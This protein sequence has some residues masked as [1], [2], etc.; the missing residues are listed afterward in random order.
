M[1]TA[2]RDS[3]DAS[4]VW[5]TGWG[6]AISAITQAQLTIGIVTSAVEMTITR[7]SA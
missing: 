4:Q 7:D 5:D 3:R 6:S 1:S 2:S